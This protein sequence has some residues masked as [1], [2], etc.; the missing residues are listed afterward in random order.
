[1]HTQHST[2]EDCIYSTVESGV[3]SVGSVADAE[4]AYAA[5]LGC[6]MLTGRSV[7]YIARHVRQPDLSDDAESAPEGDSWPVLVEFL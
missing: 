7:G 5:S 6:T 3:D 2:N 1:M 4:D